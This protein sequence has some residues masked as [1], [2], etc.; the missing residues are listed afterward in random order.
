MIFFRIKNSLVQSEWIDLFACVFIVN[1]IVFLEWRI[2]CKSHSKT[3][4]SQ[5]SEMPTIWGGRGYAC[6]GKQLASITATV[7]AWIC[8]ANCTINC[9]SWV[10]SHLAVE[11]K[12]G[13]VDF[14]LN[15]TSFSSKP[16][17]LQFWTQFKQ[18]RTE[19]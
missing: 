1:I 15:N 14:I 3:V 8:L 18:L 16:W 17:S 5:R 12:W 19:A 4:L 9:N 13:W 11:W 10:L 7:Y 6:V 2:T